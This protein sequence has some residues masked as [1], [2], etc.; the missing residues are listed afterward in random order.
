MYYIQ[1]CPTCGRNLRI[2]VAYLGNRVV[3]QHCHGRFVATDPHS[4][5]PAPP[6][7]GIG[8]LKRADHLLELADRYASHSAHDNRASWRRP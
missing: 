1:E 8:L 7:S 5:D 3:C 4:G 2:R 6:D